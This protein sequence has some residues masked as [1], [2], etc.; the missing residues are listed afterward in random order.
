MPSLAYPNIGN[1]IGE[2]MDTLS[3]VKWAV[4]PMR[5]ATAPERRICANHRGQ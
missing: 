2:C 4:A 1:K 5:D 3:P